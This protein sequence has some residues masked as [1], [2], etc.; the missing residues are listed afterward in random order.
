MLNQHPAASLQRRADRLADVDHLPM[1]VDGARFQPG[2]VEKV[3]H[4]AVQAFA[5]VANSGDE[6]LSGFGA[7]KRI[8]GLQ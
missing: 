4:E 3:A 5:F 6:V 7:V 1:Q 8:V 2:H